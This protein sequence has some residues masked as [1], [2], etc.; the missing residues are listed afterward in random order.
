MATIYDV[1]RQAGVSVATVSAV[2]NN[3]AYVS[4]GLQERVESAITALSY[5]PNQLARSLTVKQTHTIGMIIPDITNPIYPEMVRGAEDRAQNAGYTIILG[6]SDN[7]K[8]KEEAYLNVFLSKKVDGIL[9]IKAPEEMSP[10]MLEKLRQ[11]PPLVLLDRE[12]PSL[13]A[14]TVIT[15]AIGGAREAVNYLIKLGHQRVGIITGASTIH[16]RFLGYRKALEENN[17]PFD[18]S[19]A[20]E[21]HYGIDLGYEAASRVLK[22][23]PTAIFITNTSMIVGFM[24]A[25]DKLRLRC[26][27]DI[28]MVSYD[29]LGW[30]EEFHPTVTSV[31]QPK[32]LLGSRGVEILLG[33]IKGKHKRPKVEVAKNVLHYRESSGSPL[34]HS[35]SK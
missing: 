9:L 23:N 18:E 1:A 12:Y 4:P 10:P 35:S 28:A 34:I 29:D 15:D 26:P 30:S 2:V 6:N 8:G 17:I 33:R 7:Q 31:E 14:Y 24:R 5:T 19:L 27:E 21:G 20:A 13:Q 32:Y 22:Q 16:G 11:G 25:L 3:S